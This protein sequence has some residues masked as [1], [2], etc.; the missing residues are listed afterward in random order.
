V[1]YRPHAIEGLNL[2][3]AV[4]WNDTK[5]TQL[6]NLPCFG[7]QMVSEGCNQQFTLALN[8]ASPG[9]VLV[10]GVYGYYFAQ[11]LSGAP[12]IRAPKWQ[13]NF[14]FDYE[15]PVGGG[16]RLTF[17]DSNYYTSKFL[18]GPGLRSDFYQQGYLKMDLGLSLKGKDNKWELA[19]IGKN[20]TNR[21][22]T[23]NCSPSN[24]QNGLLGGEITGGTARGPAGVDEMLCYMDQGREF[25]IRLT[26]RPNG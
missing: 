4:N 24:F 21:L 22:T 3:G 13:V 2:H 6:N 26:L 11:N 15:L 18:A 20:V 1:N 7:G 14:G 17:T 25:W 23:S 12:F 16:K 9:A 19:L 5:F 10:N 8:Q